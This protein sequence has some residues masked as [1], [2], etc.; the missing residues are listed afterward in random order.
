MVAQITLA[1]TQDSAQRD[2]RTMYCTATSSVGKGL[3]SL[4][5]TVFEVR[6]GDARTFC[7]RM[8]RNRHEFED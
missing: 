4:E 6:E 7:L 8:I 2:A 5:W 1:S 3:K